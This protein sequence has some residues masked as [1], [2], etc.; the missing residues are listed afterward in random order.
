MNVMINSPMTC[1]TLNEN[2]KSLMVGR[3]KRKILFGFNPFYGF[4][5][6][7]YSFYK[8]K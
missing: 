3:K 4:N 2:V 6:I 7:H 5:C 8:H 1:L